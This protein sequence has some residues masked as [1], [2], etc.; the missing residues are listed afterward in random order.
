MTTIILI[1]LLI[2]IGILVVPFHIC[3]DLHNKRFKIH[4]NFK[5][6]WM[7]IKLIQR[8][9]PPKEEKKKTEEKT[10]EKTEFNINRIPKIISLLVESWPSL[11]RILNAFLRSTSIEKLSFNLAFGLGDYVDT[12]IVNGYLWSVVPLVN[13]IP[14]TYF[15]IEPDFLKERLDCYLEVDVKIRLL[16]IIIEFIRAYIKK[17]VRMLIGELR[18]MRG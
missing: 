16:W 7:R 15:S 17:P 10:K 12:A 9:I 3:L 6:T 4:G 2:I 1:F 11:E 5:L 13:I 14:N 18:E 8:D